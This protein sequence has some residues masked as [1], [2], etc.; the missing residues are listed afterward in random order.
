MASVIGELDGGG[1]WCGSYATAPAVAVVGGG[2]GHTDGRHA[3]AGMST[4]HARTH[5]G[6]GK[7]ARCAR[8]SP[9]LRLRKHE[10][11]RKHTMHVHMCPAIRTLTHVVQPLLQ[12]EGSTCCMGPCKALTVR[13]TLSLDHLYRRMRGNRLLHLQI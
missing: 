7:R 10:Q 11:P 6:T 5:A 9:L 1:G 12:E 13:G 3:H 8:A 2:G 4:L